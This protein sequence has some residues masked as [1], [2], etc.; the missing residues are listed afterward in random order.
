MQLNLN[1]RLGYIGTKNRLI[2][3]DDVTVAFQPVNIH[4]IVPEGISVG[5]VNRWT[6][7]MNQFFPFVFIRR[8]KLHL[9][10]QPKLV[11][12]KE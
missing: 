11:T 1:R 5:Y 3:T 9:T 4:T 7:P 12:V 6:A 2:H 10:A 8:I